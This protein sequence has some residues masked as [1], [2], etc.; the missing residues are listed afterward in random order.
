MELSAGLQPIQLANNRSVLSVKFR[1][2]SVSVR[3]ILGYQTLIEFL[4]GN[5]LMNHDAVFTILHDALSTEHHI[6]PLK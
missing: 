6:I 5:I 2:Q 3:N 4:N 1:V